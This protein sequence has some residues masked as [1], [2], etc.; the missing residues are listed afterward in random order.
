M[1]SS[2]REEARALPELVPRGK[3]DRGGGGGGGVNE[4][5]ARVGDR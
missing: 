3:G 5:R 1:S 2:K 4:R